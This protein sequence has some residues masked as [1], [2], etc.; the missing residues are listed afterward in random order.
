MGPTLV[1]CHFCEIHGP[2]CVF[3]T[4]C[5][6]LNIKIEPTVN[7]STC[8]GC[9][10]DAKGL[11]GYVWTDS[12][13][14]VKYVSSP[15][16]AQFPDVNIVR[17]SCIRSLSCEL[18]PEGREGV[19]YF[20]DDRRAHVLSNCFVL[21]D[22]QA[23]GFQRTYSF[24]VIHS[25]RNQLLSCWSHYVDR[26]DQ[27]IGKLK[28]KANSVYEKEVSLSQNPGQERRSIRL[29]SAL[30]VAGRGEMQ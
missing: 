7:R 21:K 14:S 16:S 1:F 12:E 25:D 3:R 19:V 10:F 11:E 5:V 2:S 26:I 6:A 24:L 18:Y 13:A 4:D 28:S 30:Q 15:C 17:Q 9:S 8:E 23:R 29:E 20:G 22:S 27:L